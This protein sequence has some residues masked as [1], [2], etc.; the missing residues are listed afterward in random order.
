METAADKYISHGKAAQNYPDW[1][2]GCPG[3]T[4]CN[5]SNAN[6]VS[7]RRITIGHQP[8]CISCGDLHY[9]HESILCENCA[10]TAYYCEGCGARVDE[11]DAYLVNGEVY[12]RDCVEF[13]EVCGEAILPE[14]GYE[15]R[16]GYV[17][18]YC[19]DRDYC[20]PVDE[21]DYYYPIE[22]CVYC[23]ET[24]EWYLGSN[25]GYTW[26]YC[27]E[28]GAV[29][30]DN[31]TYMCYK[32]AYCEDCFNHLPEE[33]IKAFNDGEPEPEEGGIE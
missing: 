25:E 26:H 3:S 13:C 11:D 33:V 23:E 32:G 31:D 19:C 16:N 28:C 18:G 7:P 5:I 22:D 24:G 17:C 2:P 30:P 4:H 1:E 15:T 8:R 6:K 21:D 29:V 10:G 9:N 14:D 12:C 20:Y 27:C